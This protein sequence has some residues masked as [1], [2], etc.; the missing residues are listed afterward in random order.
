MQNTVYD[1]ETGCFAWALHNMKQGKA[2]KRVAW[3]GYWKMET[4]DRGEQSEKQD[5][6]MYCKDG[7]VVRLSEGCNP[8]LTAENMAASDWMVLKDSQVDELD[9]IRRSGCLSTP[10]PEADDDMPF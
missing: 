6:V 7:P 3:L 2:V 8:V 10:E 4:F 1:T 9:K 5:I